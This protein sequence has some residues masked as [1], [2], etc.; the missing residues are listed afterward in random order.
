LGLDNEPACRRGELV[1]KDE[2]SITPFMRVF[3]LQKGF[4][5]D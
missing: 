5:A 3:V 1:V 4:A 2:F